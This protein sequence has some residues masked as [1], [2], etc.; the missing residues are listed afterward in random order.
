MV[1]VK[2][3]V[4][5]VKKGRL[6]ALAVII[7]LALF[8]SKLSQIDDIATGSQVLIRA[9]IYFLV[10]YFGLLW[11]L[12]FQVGWKGALLIIPQS[13]LFVFSEVVF[14][15]LFFFRS[16]ARVYEGILLFIL[17]LILFI[18]TYVS[19]LTTNVF[20]VSEFKDIPLIQVGKTSSFVLS[21]FMVYFITFALLAAGLHILFLA[22]LSFLLYFAIVY[23]HLKHVSLPKKV[24]WPT[25][26]SISWIMFVLFIGVVFVVS[27]HE[28]I[29]IVPTIAMAA[30]VGVSMRKNEG[31]LKW[32]NVLESFIILL[33]TII[34]VVV[35]G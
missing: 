7:S 4:D 32:F 20:N 30:T 8:V 6:L 34:T 2:A 1:E 29:S 28:L 22:L 11:A 27:S 10:S 12:R 9:S 18:G 23:F 5:N 21:L 13:A 14:I 19:F 24:F 31:L 15:D 35:L 3:N 33:G 25:V 26:V 17:L 16:F